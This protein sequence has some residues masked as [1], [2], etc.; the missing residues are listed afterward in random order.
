MVEWRLESF[1]KKFEPFFSWCFQFDP[2]IFQLENFLAIG[3]KADLY[4]SILIGDWDQTFALDITQK[5][6]VFCFFHFVIFVSV[7]KLFEKENLQSYMITKIP[8][9]IKSGF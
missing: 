1:Y 9:I 5:S 8:A 3:C 2:L 4:A 7:S 6:S